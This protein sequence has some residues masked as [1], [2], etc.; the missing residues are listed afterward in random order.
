MT[1]NELVEPIDYFLPPG[2]RLEE[3]EIVR[4]LGEGG[5]GLV[6][7]A[8]DHILKQQRA[9][10]EFLPHAVAQRN[11][12]SHRVSARSG[13][14]GDIYEEGLRSF[15]NEGRLLA[16]LDHPSVV[17]VYRCIE[18]NNT[19]YL[20]MHFYEG[21]TLKQRFRR[22]DG[23]TPDAEWVARILVQVLRGLQVVHD[24]GILHRDIKPDN[25]YLLTDER[26]VLIDF[27]AAR[28]VVGG[29]TKALTGVITEGYSPIEQYTDDSSFVE[30]P[31]TDLY[32]LGATFYHL[33][34]GKKPQNAIARIAGE[35]LTLA[36]KIA[37]SSYPTPLLASIDRA[38]RIQ[39]TSRYQTAMEWLS[40]L[41]NVPAPVSKT[42]QD[43]PGFRP[44]SLTMVL[45][46][47]SLLTVI[48]VGAFV[49]TGLREER[50]PIASKQASDA[51][52]KGIEEERQGNYSIALV[53]Y[54]Y[55]AERGNVNSQFNMGRMYQDGLG[56]PRSDPTALTWFRRAAEQGHI[57]SQLQVGQMY[58]FGVGAPQDYKEAYHWLRTAAEQGS[59]EG[60]I[61]LGELYQ[62]GSGVEKNLEEAAKWYRL[63]SD[64]GHDG[65]RR[66][67]D[68]IQ[69]ELT[70]MPEPQNG[71]S[72]AEPHWQEC[73]LSSGLASEAVNKGKQFENEQNYSMALA[74]YHFAAE[75]G[76][77]EAQ[78]NLGLM[79]LWGRNLPQD[80]V[81]AVNWFRKA[82]EQGLA[83]AQ[84]S[85]G[86]MYSKGR[87]VK[88][89]DLKAAEWYRKAAEQGDAMAQFNLGWSYQN[90]RGVMRD[91]KE[92]VQWYRKAAEQGDAVAQFNLGKAYHNGQGVA[93]DYVETANWY[94]K[95]AEQGHILATMNL[96]VMYGMGLGV[97]QSDMEAVQWYAKVDRVK[98]DTNFQ[99]RMY[100]DALAG[101]NYNAE[102]IAWY[103]KAAEKGNA[104]AQYTLGWIYEN[105]DDVEKNH[106]E[107]I[108]WIQKAADQGHLN[109]KRDLK[110]ILK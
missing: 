81:E 19:A 48:V 83:T 29:R 12:D 28:R 1:S 84:N 59:T 76:E 94:R 25:I 63:A 37:K 38:L 93:Q 39:P 77:A 54:Q 53:C 99:N 104:E 31:W 33:I 9:I 66:H 41:E 20:I 96:G 69:R 64:Q 55:A 85:L 61:A 82:A 44:S 103:R 18:A 98:W 40:E 22:F 101:L 24:H 7:L 67:L 52:L 72:S 56:V 32:A 27:G 87:G 17:R 90:G 62:G 68:A 97:P 3:F 110:R 80:D 4:V 2:Y 57:P 95:A 23:T 34:I 51:E 107:A 21:E 42:K 14:C 30:G 5:F 79:Y 16:S 46:L 75:Q 15:I 70:S 105:G 89:Y 58:R 86:W 50:C 74:C 108:K 6:Y 109:A 8:Y 73:P 43:R 106:R 49:L 10:K 102:Q 65:A 45:A 71:E 78:Y 60:Q 26:P 35:D 100:V 88:R 91:D 36:V 13:E 92:A 11:Q 47:C